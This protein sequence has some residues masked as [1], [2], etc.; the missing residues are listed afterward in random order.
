MREKLTQK[1]HSLVEGDL[2]IVENPILTKGGEER[3]VEWRNRVLRDE[4]GC[5]IGTLS[6]GT[7]ITDRARAADALRT[8]E[9]R[10]R[11]ALQY[12]DIGIWDMDYTTGLLQWSEA[13]EAHYGLAPGAFERTFEAFAKRIHPQDRDATLAAIAAGMES[14]ADFA[15]EHRVVWP[16]G[17]ERWLTGAGR[18][19]RDQ[20]GNPLRGLGISLDVTD[21][22]KLEQQYHQA[23]KVEAIGR[24]TGGVA[25]DFNNVLT[26]VLSH[27]CF[28]LED[29][30]DG[31]P[32]RADAM[33]IKTAAE[34]AAG[35]TKQLLAFSRKQVLA[36]RA[37]DL[38][39][40]IADMEKMLRRLIGEDIVLIVEPEPKLG[41][42]KADRGQIEQ[43]LM[44]L[45]VNARDAMPK[46][47][48]LTLRT[49]NVQ[50][51]EEYRATQVAMTAGDYVMFSVSDS[52][53]GM[54]AE[55]QQHMFEPFFTTKETGKGTG[56]GLSTCHGIVRQSGGYICVD[57]ELGRGTVFKVYL[58]QIDGVVQA[59][60]ARSG[61]PDLRGT[62]TVLLVDDDEKVRAAALSILERRGYKVL[63]ANG[64]HQALANAE[65][66]TGVIDL[67]LSDVVMPGESGPDLVEGL[68]AARPKIA[69]LLMSGF[70]EHAVVERAIAEGANY[71][72]KP[73]TP[74]TLAG[75]VREVLDRRNPQ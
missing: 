36:P 59:Q 5:A 62:E 61:V 12:A 8:A 11:F 51:D 14:G 29:L 46:G 39:A 7:D 74:E 63:E 47:G 6:S 72:Q 35:L 37:L 25:H 53:S 41:V 75:R 71:V 1:F 56:L 42:V 60:P 10:M 67:V 52:G 57:S 30:S 9:E 40:V 45:A 54:S 23:Q 17:T 13:L 58:P 48:T 19:T 15:T 38:N 65:N 18:V 33:E 69:V 34:R 44:N 49:I 3:L 22:R 73:F 64:A 70:T 31:D 2:S 24:L 4:N 66:H 26:V 32:R 28:L 50:I 21:R 55:V 43:V 27:A 68:R 20:Q 16:D